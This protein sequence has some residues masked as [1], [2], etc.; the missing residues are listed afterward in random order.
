MGYQVKVQCEICEQY[1]PA[2]QSNIDGTCTCGEN[3]PYGECELCCWVE[4][5]ECPL[6]MC[7]D[8]VQQAI[9]QHDSHEYDSDEIPF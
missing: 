5:V 1:K 8:C 6:C 7:N 4:H 3:L 9:D 2:N